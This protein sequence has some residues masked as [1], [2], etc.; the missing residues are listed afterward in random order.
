MFCGTLVPSMLAQGR[1]DGER[2][3]GKV[4][5][6]WTGRDDICWAWQMLQAGVPGV[7]GWVLV[8]VLVAALVA[9]L[10]IHLSGASPRKICPMRASGVMRQLA[11]GSSSHLCSRRTS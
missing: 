6:A 9:V 1:A 10:V 7:D 2:G 3:G 5:G 8:A 4:V 11:K